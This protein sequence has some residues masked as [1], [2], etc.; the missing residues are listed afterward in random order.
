MTWNP[1]SIAQFPGL[2]L[3]V[4]PV[5]PIPLNVAVTS[6]LLTEGNRG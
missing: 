5:G 6:L 1:L 4:V 3:F 2:V